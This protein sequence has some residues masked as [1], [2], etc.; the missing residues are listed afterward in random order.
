MEIVRDPS[1]A[2]LM[3]SR[4]KKDHHVVPRSALVDSGGSRRSIDHLIA[5][6]TVTDLSR[7]WFGTEETPEKVSR[8]LRLGARLTCSDALE[9]HGVWVI[10]QRSTHIA[11][12]RGARPQGRTLDLRMHKYLH[13]WPDAEP[14]LPVELALDHLA[15]CQGP[16]R[17]AIALESVANQEMLTSV[18]IAQVIAGLPGRIREGIGRIEPR[19]QSGTETRVRRFLERMGVRVEAQW[20]VG[21]V[22]FTDMRVGERLIIECD[23]AAYHTDPEAYA[24]DRRRDQILIALGYVVLRFTWEDVIQ[25]WTRTQRLLCSIISDSIHRVPRAKR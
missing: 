21:G 23:S 22:G 3:E 13:S 18:E 7:G 10:R 11:T 4:H 19:A 24:E 16:E 2:P 9:L 17:A 6:G 25:R 12:L 5:Q 1:E 14:I 15:R 8:A 20:E